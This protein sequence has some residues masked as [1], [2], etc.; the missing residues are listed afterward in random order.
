MLLFH[1]FIFLVLKKIEIKYCYKIIY[2]ITMPKTNVNYH[3]TRQHTRRHNTY[4]KFK[5]YVVHKSNI[6]I[7]KY[8]KPTQN[9]I[10]FTY[11]PIMWFT[12]LLS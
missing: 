11:M 5:P 3:S 7:P 9:N 2:N 4:K 1:F 8:T 10:Y 6:I 12:L